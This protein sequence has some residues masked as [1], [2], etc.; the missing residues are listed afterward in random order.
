MKKC[1]VIGGGIAGLT[2]TS[3]LSSKKY[4]VTLL[5]ASPKLG[6]RTYSFNDLETETII[7][8]GQHILMGCYKDTLSFLK[9]ISAENNFIYQKNLKI[10]FL[11]QDKKDHILNADKLF[12]PINLLYAII[13]YNVLTF[14][15]KLSFIGF[16]LKLPFQSKKSLKS[17]SV[18]DWL[19]RNNQTE[20]A[21]K[22][23]W[24]ILCVGALNTDIHKASS[25]VFHTIL[26][27]IFFTGNFS[28]TII[29]PKFGLSE[30]IVKPSEEFIKKN[31]GKINASESVNE[32]VIANGNIIE[33]KTDKSSYKDFD[34]V[35]ST[36]PL[37]SLVK[38]IDPV[39]LDINLN[40]TYST[41]LNIHIWIDNLLLA[42]KF[43]GLLNSPLHWIF[44]KDN[45]VN[46]VISNADYLVEKSKEEVF[47]F[48]VDELKKFIDIDFN[49]I[50]KY[51][52]IKE[53]RATF[54]PAKE[55]L[56]ARPNSKTNYKN[57]FLA[58]DWTNT[59]LPST[60]ESAAKSGRIAAEHIFKM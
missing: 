9:L 52:I 37:F 31:G 17:I 23:F 53:K 21:I 15:E 35:I 4:S 41:I 10:N 14:N 56:E 8:N 6:G 40:L 27:K 12:Y 43:Y 36:I 51:K 13:N 5:E 45:H 33:L 34:F 25:R 20:N 32:I 42:E 54:I 26:M 55:V 16:V 46:I 58:G 57:L 18:F 60:I 59:D 30:S 24:E 2:A 3:I 49:K 47:G 19:E 7:D 1:L 38:I 29:I 28:S 22:M 48:A 39:Q 50:K 11:T 44:V